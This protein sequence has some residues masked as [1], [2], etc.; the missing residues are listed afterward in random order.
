MLCFLWNVSLDSP[1]STIPFVSV[2]QNGTWLSLQLYMELRRTRKPGW[3]WYLT[4]NY[5]PCSGRQCGDKSVDVTQNSRL[6]NPRE[7]WRWSLGS[8]ISHR[9]VMDR[10][11]LWMCLVT[12]M[13]ASPP[14]WYP[15]SNGAHVFSMFH[16]FTV[17]SG[18]CG[19]IV[20]NFLD[21][22]PF[23]RNYSSL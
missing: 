19:S 18:L 23:S 5:I 11:R 7:I 13:W 6:L 21:C 16:S 3:C 8:L 4:E 15:V 20:F 12:G 14:R 22:P 1:P 9:A 10:G 2:V 17:A